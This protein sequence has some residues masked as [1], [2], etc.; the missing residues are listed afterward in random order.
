MGR[1]TPIFARERTVRLHNQ[2]DLQVKILKIT[3]IPRSTAGH[4]ILKY[5]RDGHVT[6]SVSNGRPPKVSIYSKRLLGQ[7]SNACPF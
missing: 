4:F 7:F 2:N 5:K 3:G 1:I 6:P